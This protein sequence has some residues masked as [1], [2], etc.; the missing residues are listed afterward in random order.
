[1]AIY[2]IGDLHLSTNQ[3]TNKSMEKFGKRWLGYTDKL[4]KNW[5]AVVE[6]T[7]TVVIPGDIS[8]AMRLEEALSDFLFLDSLPGTKLIGKGNHDFWWTTASKM[9]A[10]FED[11]HISSVRILNN[12][13]YLVEDQVIC[14]TR[15]WFLDERQQVTVG[16]VDY[17]KI[18]NREVVR[19]RL[20]LDSAVKL[21][22]EYEAQ[23]GTRPPMSVFLHFPPVWVDF[24]C[25]PF[26]DVLHE[27]GDPSCYF[28]HIHG[29]YNSPREFEFEGIS[30]RLVSSDAMDFTLYR[31]P[32]VSRDVVPDQLC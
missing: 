28:G 31:L 11:N 32:P 20:S 18:V 8:W 6:P 4:L 13:A 1:M 2:T 25:R 19:L 7:D 26:V 23:H 9:N 29:I 15:G 24:I 14:G 27:Y 12:N 22:D 21:C 16:S 30:L 17:D 5:T 10:F 3:A